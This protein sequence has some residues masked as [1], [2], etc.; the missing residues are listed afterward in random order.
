MTKR[1]RRHFWYA[2]GAMHL[3][4]GEAQARMTTGIIELLLLSWLVQCGSYVL[5]I[6]VCLLFHANYGHTNTL[7]LLL[8]KS[9]T[10]KMA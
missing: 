9:K 8:S 5:L 10:S 4:S 1:T 2:K 3:L 7:I 6:L